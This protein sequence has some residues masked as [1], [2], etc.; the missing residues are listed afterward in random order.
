MLKIIFKVGSN[1]ASKLYL[2]GSLLRHRLFLP[3]SEKDIKQIRKLVLIDSKINFPGA[4]YSKFI[5]FKIGVLVGKRNI[6]S[7]Q[8]RQIRLSINFNRNKAKK[9]V[10]DLRRLYAVHS[11]K[12]GLW[13]TEQKFLSDKEFTV[14]IISGLGENAESLGDVMVIGDGFRSKYVFPVMLEEL[15]HGVY[16][17]NKRKIIKM[18]GKQDEEVVVG[19]LLYQILNYLNYDKKISKSMV[20]D[21]HGGNRASKVRKLIGD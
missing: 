11:E 20:F 6:L 3:I 5:P 15:L 12:I 10:K 14:W 4:D 2:A 17:Y 19:Y 1:Q 18:I 9:L 8:L 7:R 13:L 16:K 21:W